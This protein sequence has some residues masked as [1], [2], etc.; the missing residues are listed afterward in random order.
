MNTLEAIFKRKSVRTYKN[1]QID[2]EK[3]ELILKAAYAAP[4]GRALYENVHLTVITKKDLLEK[5]NLNAA[6]FF[7]NSNLSPLYGAPT[8][9]LISAKLTGA[10]DNVG[11]S[12]CACIAENIALAATELGLGACHIWGATIALGQNAELLGKMK[13]PDG[14]T[15]CC[16]VIIGNTDEIYCEKNIPENRIKTDFIK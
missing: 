3:T 1:E 16:G 6:K 4:V 9:I 8:F 13:L 11:F 2:E 15:P 12:N 10:T 7:G 5:I 14:F